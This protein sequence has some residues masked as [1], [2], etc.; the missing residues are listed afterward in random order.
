MLRGDSILRPNKKEDGNPS[1]GQLIG[2]PSDEKLQAEFDNTVRDAF[3]GMPKARSDHFQA[4]KAVYAAM[5]A[6]AGDRDTSVL[7]LRRWKE[8]ITLTT[9]DIQIHNGRAIA[10]P[11]GQDYSQF[12]DG[13]RR[14]LEDLVI[15][16]RLDERWGKF[17]ALST[18]TQAHVAS[19]FSRLFDLPLEPAGDGKYRLVVGGAYLVDK[20]GKPVIL[21][22]S[23]S[24]AFR[25]SGYMFRDY[26]AEPTNEE[27]AA[28]QRPFLGP[29]GR[30]RKLPTNK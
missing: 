10:L 11:Y 29:V 14:R 13:L 5:T 2:L 3:A 28:A 12:K 24:A 18:D 15:S 16:G 4:A 7:N 21:D 25:T 23:N 27:L 6:D 26:M 1:K 22:F 20:Q 8:A 19:S 9:G 17:G 30:P